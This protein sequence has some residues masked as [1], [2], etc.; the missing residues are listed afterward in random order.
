MDRHLIFTG[1]PSSELFH[2]P[3]FH[4]AGLR[5]EQPLRGSVSARIRENPC[6]LDF[7][8]EQLARQGRFLDSKSAELPKI[9]ANRKAKR[10]KLAMFGALRLQENAQGWPS[11]SFCFLVGTNCPTI[12][13]FQILKATD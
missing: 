4:S 8:V 3:H 11:E 10:M 1:A 13:T 12:R 7:K 9:R 2:E 5:D 6:K